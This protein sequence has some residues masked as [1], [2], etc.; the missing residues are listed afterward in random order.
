VA[1][2]PHQELQPVATQPHQE[3][4]PVA[5]QPQQVLAIQDQQLCVPC[6]VWLKPLHGNLK[7]QAPFDIKVSSVLAPGIGQ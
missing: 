3:L 2:Q 6:C 5:T 4:Q 1:T 7:S